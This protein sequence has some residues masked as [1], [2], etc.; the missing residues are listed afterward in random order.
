MTN[1]NGND[2]KQLSAG[3][4]LFLYLEREC[5]PLSIGAVMEFEGV[6]RLSDCLEF[7][8]S[9]LPLIPRYTQRVVFPPL[10][11]GHPVWE[12]DPTF[13]IRNHVREIKLRDGTE[14]ELKS[15]ASDIFS[16]MLDRNHPLWD[17]TLIHGLK[18]KRT[19]VLARVH[20]CLADGIAGV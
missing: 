16:V 9:K 1:V 7:V 10:N 19:G 3:D 18:E 5:S 20:H 8:K 4:S 11:S 2:R 14:E 12:P 13:D 15:V 6:M 17:I